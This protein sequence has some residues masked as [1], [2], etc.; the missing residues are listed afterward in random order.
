MLSTLFL[1]RALTWPMDAWIVA[2]MSDLDPRSSRPFLDLRSSRQSL[3]P[4]RTLGQ[5][6][7]G[8][9]VDKSLLS[10]IER[11]TQGISCPFARHLA[12]YYSRVTGKCVT[13][14]EVFNMVERGRAR[15]RSSSW[16]SPSC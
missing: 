6:A 1:L 9:Q 2:L 3:A 16:S 12:R 11:G 15:R 5:V 14:G 13:P 8:A 7:R 10:R 4:R